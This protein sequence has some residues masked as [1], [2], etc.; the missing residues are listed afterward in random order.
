M[1]AGSANDGAGRIYA[2][3]RREASGSDGILDW[4][5][6][7]CGHNRLTI[8]DAVG[9]IGPGSGG[10]SDRE[11]DG[12]GGGEVSALVRV[13]LGFEA[14]GD[15]GGEAS[16][17]GVS[18]GSGGDVCQ[19]AAATTCAARAGQ[20]PGDAQIFCVIAQGGDEYLRLA[21]VQGDGFGSNFQRDGGASAVAAGN[22]DCTQNGQ[23]NQR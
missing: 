1:G 14:R 21:F 12:N 17:R 16:R 11:D 23:Q 3:P 18:N 2:Q 6:A 4:R 10:E 13:D 19:G 9:A 5:Y 15:G 22:R 8:A 7:A 20:G